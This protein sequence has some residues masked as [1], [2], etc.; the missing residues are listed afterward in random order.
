MRGRPMWNT[1]RAP[2]GVIALIV[3]APIFFDALFNLVVFKR[4]WLRPIYYATHGLID[5]TLVANAVLL[6]VVV[7]G[8]IVWMGGLGARDLGMSWAKLRPGVLFG[9]VLWAIVNLGAIGYWLAQS[10]ML[11]LD[12]AWQKPLANIGDL[13]GQIFG[14][15][16]YEEIVYRG[17][18]TVQIALLLQR[19][20]KGTALIGGVVIAQGIFAV[21]HVPMLI[22]TGHD[23]SQIASFLPQVFAIGCILAAIYL[24]TG[25][26]FL[27]VAP[28]ALADA[29]ML[30]FAAPKE[31]SDAFGF[32][33]P[34]LALVIVTGW[35]VM[36][37]RKEKEPAL[38][39]ALL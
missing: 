11:P 31:N 17:F 4:G 20:G 15:A 29:Y 18:L 5:V 33:Y 27:A 34:L 36:R 37:E 35:W 24:M 8:M 22:V 1:R 13:L 2:F 12:P 3:L 38:P 10:K 28:H 6:G 26:L 39:P 25:N 19:F 16:L 7:I 30:I 21:I 32:A 14:N 9:F 23:W